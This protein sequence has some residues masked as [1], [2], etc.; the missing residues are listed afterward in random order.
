MF[1]MYDKQARVVFDLAGDKP[2]PT[3]VLHEGGAALTAKRK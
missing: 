3:F 1:W 2:A